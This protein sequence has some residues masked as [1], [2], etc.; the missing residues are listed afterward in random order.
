M[1]LAGRYTI[2]LFER[3]EGSGTEA[4]ID[5]DDRLDTA[6]SLYSRGYEPSE[7]AGDAA[8]PGPR[9]RPR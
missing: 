7:P 4:V 9:S 3:D 1:G 8:R 5:S 2:E 6:R